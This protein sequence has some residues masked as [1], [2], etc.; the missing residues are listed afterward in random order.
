MSALLVGYARC[1]TDQQDL[2][3]QRDALLGLGVEV[4]RIYVDHGLTGTNREQ[5]GLREALAACRA[6]DTLVVTKLDRLARS[7][8]DARA[9]ADE[10]TARQISL[11]LGGSVY[12]PT[13]AVG[14]LLF[15]VLAM[16]A[17]FESDLIRR[18]HC[19]GHEGRQGEG[20]AARQAAQAQREA[21]SAPGLVGA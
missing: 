15:N 18:P 21:R 4:E 10:L 17:E 13:D 14:R 9:I 20:A 1:S 2:T 3:A 5:P 7:L 19:R 11:S 12:D 16:V 8:P 6:G